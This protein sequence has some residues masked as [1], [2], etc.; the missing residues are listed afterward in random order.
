MLDKSEIEL[1]L[2]DWIIAKSNESSS[3]T[4][5][6]E[7]EDLLANYFKVNLQDECSKKES[8][9]AYDVRYTTR[10]NRKIDAELLRDV[11]LE[12]GLEGQLERL[13][14]WKPELSQAAWKA[15]DP[16]ITDILCN[17]ITITPGRP[18]FS[19]TKKEI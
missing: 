19:I 14:R 17:A 13:F 4:R 16:A 18:S 10:H 5:R 7:I 12:N 2:E 15:A 6:Q 3:K 1:M 11:A 9:G 8:V